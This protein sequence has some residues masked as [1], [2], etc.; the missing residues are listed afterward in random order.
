MRADA[1]F[2]SMLISLSIA[3]SFE[4]FAAVK[5]AMTGAYGAFV[6]TDSL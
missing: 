2:R 6:N 1:L 3:G 4:D 5:A